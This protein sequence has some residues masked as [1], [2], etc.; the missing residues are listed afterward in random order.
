MSPPTVNP[1]ELRLLDWLAGCALIG[2]L[3]DSGGDLADDVIARGA[4]KLAREMLVARAKHVPQE[5][6]VVSPKGW[7]P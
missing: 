1:G 6:A 3:A 7:A 2:I 5:E 4:Y